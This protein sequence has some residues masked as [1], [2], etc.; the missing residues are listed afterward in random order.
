M[1]YWGPYLTVSILNCHWLDVHWLLYVFISS[2]LHQL[3]KEVWVVLCW[4]SSKS[5]LFLLV[6]SFPSCSR[7]QNVFLNFLIA[8]HSIYKWLSE[9]EGYRWLA[10]FDWSSTKKKNGK[11]VIKSLDIKE[12]DMS[13][14]NWRNKGSIF[15]EWER[16]SLIFNY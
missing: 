4:A 1:E 11:L 14:S 9:I 7:V 6:C 12:N 15:K 5:T 3:S 10:P 2:K 13:K 16:L 8:Q